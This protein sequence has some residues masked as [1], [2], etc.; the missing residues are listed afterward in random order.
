MDEMAN[1][2]FFHGTLSWV[3]QF[4]FYFSANV[5]SVFFAIPFPLLKADRVVQKCPP[6]PE[7]CVIR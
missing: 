2:V 3:V 5:L 6:E 4:S 7:S 1:P